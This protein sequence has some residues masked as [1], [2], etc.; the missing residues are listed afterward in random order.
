MYFCK[1]RLFNFSLFCRFM[2]VEISENFIDIEKIIASKNPKLLKWI[3]GFVLRYMKR[4]LHIDQI[5]RSIYVHREKFGRDFAEAILDDFKVNIVV[6][7]KENIPTD[8][9]ERLMVIANHPLGGV[10]GM[11]LISEIGKVREDIQ[12]PVN[13]LLLHLPGLRP[14]FIPINKYGDNKENINVLENA[15]ASDNT[16]LYFPAGLC[17]RKQK[18][19]ILDL[20]WKTTFLKKA[21]QYKRDLLPVMVDAKNTKRFYNLSNFRKKVGIKANIE[22]VLLPDEMYRQEGKTIRLIIGKPIS[23]QLFDNSKKTIEWVKLLKQHVYN[24]YNNPDL[25]FNPNN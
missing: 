8:K 12:F 24:L 4:L 14:V 6:E 16:L 19:E 18:G 7:G 2:E 5:N 21:I 1:L 25:E 13:D 3:P 17:S 10:D 20:E 9:E 11:A 15:F 23:Y 22:L